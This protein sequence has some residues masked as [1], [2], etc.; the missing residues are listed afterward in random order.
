MAVAAVR[1]PQVA[2]AARLR[3]HWGWARVAVLRGL[4]RWI[5]GA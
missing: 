1:E 2:A 5:A 4:P 3:R